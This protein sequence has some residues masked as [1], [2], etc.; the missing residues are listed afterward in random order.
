MKIALVIYQYSDSKG[1]VERYVCDL[2][3]GL[4][5][6]GN[7]VHIFSHKRDE[8]I[9]DHQLQYHFVPVSWSFYAP[10]RMKSFAD[11]SAKLL[12]E[13]KFDIIQGFGRTYYQDILRFGSGCHWEYLKHTHPEMVHPLGRLLHK[14]NPRNQVILSLEKRSLV[15][16][17]VKKIICISQLCQKEILQYYDLPTDKIVV[18]YNGIDPERFS[19]INRDKFRE[20][21]RKE[22]DLNPQDLALLFVGSGFERKGLKY[23]IEAVSL[24]SNWVS[25]KLIVIGKGKVNKYRAIARKKGIEKQ[26]IFLGTTNQIEK[27]YAAADIFLFPSLYDAFGTVVL[28]AMASGLPVVV[29]RFCGASEILT[30]MVDSF[31]LEDPQ[32][33]SEIARRIGYLAD[34]TWRENMGKAARVTSLKYTFQHNLEK[35]LTVYQEVLC[36]KME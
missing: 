18:I 9:N 24:V 22:L 7:E 26:V 8:Q 16:P 4:V 15:N 25:V 23:A 21:T 28:E 35:T 12:K 2:A 10:L 33:S 5:Q 29:S 32:D 31:I 27:Y 13:K 11:N 30:H 1:G 14:L 36:Q 3:R 34:I 19:P 17:M 20:A 6:R